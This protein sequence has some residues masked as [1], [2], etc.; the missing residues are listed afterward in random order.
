MLFLKIPCMDDL[1]NPCAS[2]ALERLFY[3]GRSSRDMPLRH[4]ILHGRD[5]RLE[6]ARLK[7]RPGA[8]AGG[9]RGRLLR[10][11]GRTDEAAAELDRAVAAVPEDPRPYA[12]RWELADAA[13][14]A[15]L[16]DIDRAV[17]LGEG[18]G[19]WRLWRA[20]ARL[21]RAQPERALEDL[22]AALG[23]EDPSCAPRAHFAAALA[24][25]RLGRLDAAL[26][27]VDAG[28]ALAP[29]VEWAHRLRAMC[30]YE[31]GDPGCVDDCARAMR[32]NEM[33]GT[34]FIPLGLYRGRVSEA[35][36]IAAADAAIAK[37]PGAYWAY[38][39]RSDYKRGPSFNDNSGAL[40]DL[41]RAVELAPKCAWAWAY[42]AR[43]HTVAGDFSPAGAALERAVALD[44]GCGWIAAWKGEALRRRGDLAGATRS[45]DRAAGLD[46]DYELTYAWRGALRR[47]QDRPAEALEDLDV[48]VAL[49]PTNVASC[50]FERHLAK[51]G[52]R[53][54]SEALDDIVTAHRLNDR[55]VWENRPA[56]FAAALREL[57]ALPR[58]RDRNAARAR[59]WRGEIMIR[60]RR[61][62]DAASELTRALRLDPALAEA[63][64]LR[65]R[66]L[67]ELGRWPK[68]LADFDAAAKLDECSPSAHAWRGRALMLRG[69]LEDALA[70][71][72][73][74]LALEPSAAWVLAWKGEAQFRL[75]RH[76][77]AI[78][79][80]TRALEISA[81]FAD[82]LLWRGA[83]RLA[84][85]EDAAALSDL[86]QAAA[87]AP[88]R[89]EAR[90]LLDRARSRG[91]DIEKLSKAGDHAAA[92]AACGELLASGKPPAEILPRRAEAL[93]CLGR[94]DEA[95][96]DWTALVKL[97]PGRADPLIRRGD[98]RRR[99]WDF[100]GGL[101][102]ARA[103]LRLAPGSAH[104]WVLR[105]ECERALGLWTR[106]LSSADAAVA[107]EPGWTW[108][109]IVRAKIRRQSGDLDG[110][111]EDTVR[112]EETAPDPYAFA[113]RGEILRKLGRPREA[114]A[115]L[116]RA[117]ALQP[118]NA[119]LYALRGETR[120]ELG[121][122]GAL[123]DLQK[124]FSLDPHASCD[125]DFLG[126]EPA[127]VRRDPALSW[128]YAWRGGI[129][130]K[131]GRLREAGADLDRAVRLDPGCFWSLAWRG[132]LRVN[133]GR[134]ASGVADLRR[135]L[136]LNP[137]YASAWLWLGQGLLANSPR[138]ARQAYRKARSLDPQNPWSVIGEAACF[139]RLGDARQANRL[140]SHARQLAPSLFEGASE[141]GIRVQAS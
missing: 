104:A 139:E 77:D 94:N 42:L 130:R 68:A 100:R 48:A 25:R 39:Y 59:L 90:T 110:A 98:S 36:N 26:R 138:H 137:K 24:E 119:W 135:A 70:S 134:R 97:Q 96:L 15:P 30:R 115:C 64:V 35:E 103:A 49:A 120:R 9:R 58:R 3:L 111:L 73:R 83:A 4:G 32:L 108:P 79:D 106:A 74:S 109:L 12:W 112:A 7:G 86:E 37:E 44:P 21:E 56:H 81:R 87:L 23:D 85:G 133:R 105:A 67:G 117:I 2:A 124:A 53:Q 116:D 54:T 114:I 46:A 80:L 1:E 18:S 41:K 93:R 22:D 57:A 8:A 118:T 136:K 10:L 78:R 29:G 89:E 33:V 40:A 47:A 132:E 17:A 71:L 16:D 38:V 75:G 51:R 141:N 5:I 20:L 128:V 28:L 34:L 72:E 52:L 101:R 60:S 125:F 55:F 95:L 76:D 69:R 127:A 13:L 6:L 65:G 140:L 92:A 61:F 129:R 11:L 50:Y 123:A 99:V 82:A 27:R 31:L 66:A 122:A 91:A 131:N 62:S 45:F 102:D 14:R 84:K 88:G 107:A 113:W 63:R 43:A 19:W 126:A 121:R